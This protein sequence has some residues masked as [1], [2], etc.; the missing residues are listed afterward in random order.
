MDGTSRSVELLLAVDRDGPHTLGAQIE[1]QL[2]TAIRTGTLRPGAEIPSTRDLARQLGISRRVAV[3]AYAQLAAEGYL[4]I[5]QGARPRVSET[6]VETAPTVAGWRGGETRDAGPRGGGADEPARGGGPLAAPL[7]AAAAPRAA[8]FDFRPSVP[9]VSAFPRAAWLKSLRTAI[10]NATDAELQYGDPTGDDVLKRVLADYLGRVR[11]VVAEPGRVVVTNGFGQSLNLLCGVLRRGGAK[12]VALESPSNPENREVVA[13]AGLEPVPVEV[14]EQGIRVD[15]LGD[16]D[17]VLITPAHQHPTGVVLTAERRAQLLNWLRDRDALAIEDDYDA[18][19]RYDRAAIGA[20]QGLEPERI[21]YAGSAS[22]TLAP[23]LRLGWLVV[24]RRLVDPIR[25]SKYLADLGTAR[26]EQHA[27]A[28]FIA[29]G[30]LD[31]H[32]RRMRA[33]YRSRRDTLVA[34]LAAELPEATVKGIAAGLHVTVELPYEAAAI[35]EGA[36]ERRID[37]RTLEDY[38]ATGPPTLMLG[39]GALPEPAIVPGV[40]ELADLVRQHRPPR[41]V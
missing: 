17:A 27:F 15:E 2:R 18:E 40:R 24:P 19:Y 10:A 35:R 11:G 3:E 5:R 6:A 7:P 38:E 25:E 33:R 20:L 37:L 36:R 26:I 39:Y 4:S 23:A 1:E 32:L 30:E 41:D 28:D 21:V 34:A 22:K 13:R 31:R 29:R 12:R 16:V 14:D 8:R 9:D